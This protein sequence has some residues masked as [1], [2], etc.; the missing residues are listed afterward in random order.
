LVSGETIEADAVL[1]SG[2]YTPT[3][4]LYGQAQGKLRWR[5]DIQ[6]FVPDRKIDGLSVVGAAAGHFDLPSVLKDAAGAAGGEAPIADAPE[7][8]LDITAA[9]PKPGAKGRIWIDLQN[10]VTAKDVELA[11]RENFVSVEHLKRYTTLGM[12][13]DQGKTSNLPGLALMAQIT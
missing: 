9:W 8:P 10:D 13:N 3:I 12:A 1:V 7:W 4:H 6:A 5:D 2:G 11:A